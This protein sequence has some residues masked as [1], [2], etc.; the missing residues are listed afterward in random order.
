MAVSLALP[1][2]KSDLMQSPNPTLAFEIEPGKRDD[3]LTLI[4]LI[5]YVRVSLPRHERVAVEGHLHAAMETL[6]SKLPP[7]D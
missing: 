7:S 3:I 2:T 5:E 4:R 1:T 6:S